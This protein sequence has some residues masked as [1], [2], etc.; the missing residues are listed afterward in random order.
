MSA[1]FTMVG[2][3]V[4]ALASAGLGAAEA[5]WGQ[6][7]PG[8]HDL[9]EAAP[10]WFIRAA[11]VALA[12]TSLALPLTR[13]AA[14]GAAV[15]WSVALAFGAFATVSDAMNPV[16]WVPVAECAAF[17]AFAFWCADDARGWVVARAVFGVMLVLFGAIHLAQRE[18]IASLIPDWIAFG[19]YWP[20]VTGTLSVV[21]GLACLTGR[22]VPFGAGAVALMYL[23]WLPLVHA[24]RLFVDAASLFEWTFALTALAL[25][26]VALAISGRAATR[27]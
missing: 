12:L 17:A 9:P 2:V 20:L 18:M 27:R 22:G 11:G 23:S 21:A 16:A 3:W 8:L 14:F 5:I 13:L 26:G 19:A 25:A 6:W 10:V 15:L 4:F 1:R 24:P 7:L